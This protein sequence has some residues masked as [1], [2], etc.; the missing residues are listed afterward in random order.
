MA[1]LNGTGKKAS[2]DTI[3]A[4]VPVLLF[5]MVFSLIVDNGFKTMT[6]P[7]AAGLGVDGETASLQASLAGV[8]IGIFAV[9]YAALAD[10]FSVRKLMLFSIVLVT[11]GSLLGFV[12][13]AF[14]LVL[15]GR[16]IQT[17]GLAAAE[18]LYVIYVTKNL[19][20]KE[21]KKYLGFSTAAFQA[22]LLIGALTSGAISTYIG[23]RVMF[24]VPLLLLVAVPFIVK[25]VPNDY[26][27]GSSLDIVGLFLIGVATTGLILCLQDFLPAWARWLLLAAANG[28]K[29]M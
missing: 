28:S 13:T 22:G 12:A 29:T 6:G 23:W 10:V 17:C 26:T 16:L 1:E 5:T 15:L 3:K 7:M 21:Q 2:L 11:V 4:A 19:P 18:N 24:L 9:V 27:R 20:E 14:W 8:I 25:Q